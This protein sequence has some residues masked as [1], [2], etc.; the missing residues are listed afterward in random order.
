M[1]P[2]EQQGPKRTTFFAKKFLWDM[3]SN[4]IKTIFRIGRRKDYE[5]YER[6]GEFQE[7]LLVRE[8]EMKQLKSLKND[9]L[10][11]TGVGLADMERLWLTGD[12]IIIDEKPLNLPPQQRLVGAASG[13]DFNY[14][15]YSQIGPY[16]NIY[17]YLHELV[18]YYTGANFNIEDA[19]IT[20]VDIRRDAELQGRDDII[21]KIAALPPDAIRN[22]PEDGMRHLGENYKHIQVS[23]GGGDLIWDPRDPTSNEKINSFGILNIGRLNTQLG[24][25]QTNWD[26]STKKAI[27]PGAP[28]KTPLGLQFTQLL[29]TLESVKQKEEAHYKYLLGL[30][31]IIKEIPTK[32]QEII[33]NAPP[34]NRIRFGH[35]YKIIQPFIFVDRRTGAKVD[36]HSEISTLDVSQIDGLL[37]RIEIKRFE[38]GNPDYH[39]KD[40]EV[41]PMLDENGMPLEVDDDGTILMDKWWWEIGQN[42]WQL[43]RIRAKGGDFIIRRIEDIQATGVRRI[44]PEFVDY[45]DILEMA[46]YI[47]NEWDAVRDDF[48][49]KR[50]TEWSKSSHDYTIAIEGFGMYAPY[51]V[52]KIKFPLTPI[53][54]TCDPF[55]LSDTNR[56]SYINARP[57]YF[58]TSEFEP[59]DE[60]MI[61]RRFR[62]RLLDGTL[63]PTDEQLRKDEYANLR[64]PTNL[65]PGFDRRAINFAAKWIHWGRMYYYEW[66]D[67]I[68]RWS[69]NP[70]PAISSRGVSKYIIHRILNDTFHYKR[71][72]E[73]VED[74]VGY[75][76][77]IRRPIIGGEF[78]KNPLRTIV[79]PVQP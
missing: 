77:G 40:Y 14:G 47:S 49:D 78:F 3:P 22:L 25:F 2:Q 19:D 69:E 26:N 15:I 30:L 48:R 75:D 70:Y 20:M 11:S 65:N 38:N 46:T 61:G 32:R 45:M 4:R 59:P 44:D 66:V 60:K 41:G 10:T 51:P 23:I 21:R 29:N 13:V 5:I 74:E 58:E 9:L 8:P 39:V 33:R 1:P 53:R 62:M 55:D 6:P 7:A 28:I 24:I 56:Y 68:N 42:E 12:S 34:R 67:G 52:N 64:K 72:V 37:R 35:T 16:T 31:P 27:W 43:E 50:F 71:A 63:Y 76:I 79:T 17:A 18:Y 54:G 36:I 57:K 73:N